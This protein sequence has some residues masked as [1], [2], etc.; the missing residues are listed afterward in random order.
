MPHVSAKGTVV[1]S[2]RGSTSPSSGNS[3]SARAGLHVN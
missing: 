1:G 2:V 3:V